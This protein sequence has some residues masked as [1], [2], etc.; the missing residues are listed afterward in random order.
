MKFLLDMPVSAQ[1]IDVLSANGHEGVHA[2]AI[3]LDR[4]Q[5]RDLLQLAWDQDRIIITADLDFPR[6]LALSAA[7]GPGLTLA[8]IPFAGTQPP[9]PPVLFH[10]PDKGFGALVSQKITSHLL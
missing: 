5:D 7:D 10:F 3:G 8:S 4:A 2:H 6:L 9:S 1:L